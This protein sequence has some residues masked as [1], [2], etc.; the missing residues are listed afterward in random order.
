M[1]IAELAWLSR[2]AKDILS[3]SQATDDIYM[4]RSLVESSR[5]LTDAVWHDLDCAAR[6][7]GRSDD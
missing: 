5:Q 6:K 1:S 7:I 4:I 2:T 3:Y